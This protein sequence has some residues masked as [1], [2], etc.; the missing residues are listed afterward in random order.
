MADKDSK[1]HLYIGN[2][3][4]KHPLKRKGGGGGGNSDL[5]TINPRI[6]VNRLSGQLT[7]IASFANEVS[8][9]AHE[10]NIERI[11]IQITFESFE[12]IELVFNSLENAPKKIELLNIQFIDNTYYATVFVPEG[13]LSFFQK[14]LE[15]YAAT[16][17][18][19]STSHRAVIESIAAIKRATIKTLWTDSRELFPENEHD[20]VAWEVWLVR[21]DGT[22]EREFKKLAKQMELS[23]STHQI[24]FRERI[25]LYVTASLA[26]FRSNVHLLNCVAE[27]KKPKETAEF[28][29]EL[30]IEEQR[31]WIAELSHRLS[32]SR[33]EKHPRV[34]I[35]DTGVNIG[36]PLIGRFSDGQSLFTINP[37]FG[38]ADNDGHGTNMSGLALY[39]DLQ[40]VLESQNQVEIGHSVE[41]VKIIRRGGDNRNQAFGAIT[42]DATTAPETTKPNLNRIF[43]MAISADD[44][45]DNGRPSAWSAAID[46][47][48][49]NR[50][51]EQDPK[52]LFILASG[53]SKLQPIDFHAYPDCLDSQLIHDPGQSWNALTVG[54]YTEKINLTDPNYIG[55]LA[56]S[57]EISPYASTSSEW[58]D[59]KPIKPDVVFEG[60][61]VAIDASGGFTHSSLSLLTTDHDIQNR[62]F[63]TFWA[64]SAATA[65]AANFAAQI[66]SRYPKL[67]AETV[68]G[69]IVHSA[70]WNDALKAQIQ[71]SHTPKQLAA[72]LMRR[73]GYGIPNLEV[74]LDSASQRVSVII[75]DEITP[76]NKGTSSPG[77]NELV[78][79]DLP[80]PKEILQQLGALE[81]KLTVTLSYFIEPNPS[82]R[83]FSSKYSYQSHNLMFDLK[84]ALEG[85]DDLVTRINN[86]AER[87][88]GFA[89]Q[90]DTGNWLIGPQ[91]RAHGSIAK[92]V[93]TG[94]AADLAERNQIAIIPTAGWWKTR[95]PLNMYDE[96]TR[97]SLILTI[98]APECD[99][100]IY[101]A[102]NAIIESPV[103]TQLGIEV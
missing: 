18:S 39:G 11:G 95:A 21:G 9:D 47:L 55:P 48:C 85:P 64:T 88:E 72:K 31:E 63:T 29:D 36:H 62:M 71:G 26:Q 80:W 42:I 67:R 93:W 66:Y 34:T 91:N 96:R 19:E 56:K 10:E 7:D 78:T 92:D 69:L 54:A 23:V 28:F 46:E 5:P 49:F 81:I 38:T 82:N 32:D 13:K 44:S 101:S 79:H 27:L 1:P 35:L 53:N 100:D 14:K 75:E 45:R 73:V 12:G 41:S 76:F 22:P 65:L 52:R 33:D 15:E 6:H 87:P 77:L 99:V 2:N 97:Y 60:G 24:N 94:T 103:A 70:Q 20:Q 40:A 4:T 83:A 90:G 59:K 74:A 50:I 3:G 30:N 89:I 86:G 58:E 51:G 98:E 17:D 61:N 25:V 43:T 37:A 68:R 57:G 84:R 102:V 8:S 16:I